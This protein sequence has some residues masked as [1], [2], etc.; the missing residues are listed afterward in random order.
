MSIQNIW[1]AYPSMSRS[2]ICAAKVV[3][4]SE[5]SNL[6]MGA[7]PLLPSSKLQRAEKSIMMLE[8]MLCTA[9]KLM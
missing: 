7:T 6:D 4:N 5:A 9:A 3:G 2:L 8:H 1:Q